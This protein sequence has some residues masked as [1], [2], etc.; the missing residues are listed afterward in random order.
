MLQER[1]PDEYW[2]AVRALG[3]ALTP[4]ELSHVIDGVARP[5][6]DVLA[7]TASTRPRTGENGHGEH[8][9]TVK[10]AF[11]RITAV[12]AREPDSV[13]V[14]FDEDLC[15]PTTIGVDPELEAID[16]EVTSVYTVIPTGRD[17]VS[18]AP[19][20]TIG[21]RF[22]RYEVELGDGTTFTTDRWDQW[23]PCVD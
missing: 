10:D 2:L 22:G 13:T 3:F 12:V 23:T 19:I 21:T 5:T 16:D 8:L 7:T 20:D 11:A 9:P 18:I 15:H 1:E 17:H 6:G 4:P 14:A